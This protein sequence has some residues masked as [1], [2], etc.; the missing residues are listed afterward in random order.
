MEL[1]K[2]NAHP[3]DAHISFDEPTHVYT[4]DGDSTFKSVTTF[5]HDFF[6]H[7]DADSVLK[8]MCASPK[9][10]THKHYGKSPEEIKEIWRK[11]GEEAASQGTAM[12]LNIENYYNG[13]PMT[14]SFKESPEGILFQKYLDDH[15]EYKAYRTEWTV[16]SKK[17]KIAGS[18]DMV[19]ED[20]KN[21]GCH[22]IADWKRSNEIKF[23]NKWE[24]GKGP[25]SHLD[26]CNYWHYT[27]QLNIYRMLLEKYYDKVI[28]DMFLVVLHP[29]NESYLKIT[30]PKISKEILD[31]LEYRKM[32]IQAA[33]QTA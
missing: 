22:V 29:N 17:Y 30:I 21:P 6:P 28:T 25:L 5:I 10:N 19:Y 20:P 12:H 27:L 13:V 4:I 1:D 23:E 14:A 8:K 11:N 32:T 18:I 26:N 2:I 31:M 9:W 24:K 15:K 33:A 16:F 7:F 3:R